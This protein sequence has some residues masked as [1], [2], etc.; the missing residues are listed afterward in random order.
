MFTRMHVTRAAERFI[1]DFY[2]FKKENVNVAAL[3]SNCQPR[4]RC[5]INTFRQNSRELLTTGKDLALW[6]ERYELILNG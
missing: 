4:D 1:H 3:S 2:C 5:N 6:H